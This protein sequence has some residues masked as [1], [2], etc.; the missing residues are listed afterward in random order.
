MDANGTFRISV[1][2]GDLTF[3][4][5]ALLLGH[6]H[7]TRLT[8]TEKIMD[9]L[10]GG[11][12]EQ[13]LDMGIYPVAI[14][15]HQI[16]INTHPNTERGIFVPHPKAVIIAG[17]GEEGKLRAADLVQSVRQAV[18]AWSQRLAEG[19]G[20]GSRAAPTTFELSSTLLG[21]GGTGVSPGEAAR[22]IAEGVYRANV[23]MAEEDEERGSSQT[24]SPRVAHLRF[25]ELYLD[26]AT[27]AWRSLRLQEAARPGRY[28][29]EEVVEEGTGALQRPLD[30]GYRGAEFDFISV[31]ATTDAGGLPVL[32]YTLDTRRA[33]SEVRAQRAQSLL[34]KELVA[35][36]SNDQNRDEQIGRTLFD[37]LIPIELEAYLAGSGEMQ[38]ELD[39]QTAAI[40]WELLDTTRA[41]DEDL[42]WALR[43]NLLRKLRISTFRERVVDAG[44]DA[45]ALVIGEPQAPAA[46]PR[47]YGARAE[48]EAVIARLAGTGGLSPDAVLGLI[49]EE[50]SEPGPGARDLVNALFDRPWRIV[51]IAGHGVPRVGGQ[52]GGVVLS[53]GAF[54][55]P[56]EIASM[57]TVPELVFLNCCHVGAAAAGELLNTYDRA[58]FASGVAG[59]LISIG[60]RCV[61]AAGWAV[62]D[63]GAKVFA[64]TFYASLVRGNRFIT[65]LGEARRAAY[66]HA[67]DQNTWAAYQC[68]GDPDWIFRQLPSDPNRVPTRVQ[69]DFSGVA[70]ATSL[71]L[72]L[73]R[74]FTEVRF[75]GADPALKLESLRQLETRYAKRWG[76]QG[77]VAEFFGDAFA[78]TG[79]IEAAFRWYEA[80]IAAPDASA[81]MRAAE[82]LSSLRIR[83][84]WTIVD[85]AARTRHGT[86]KGERSLEAAIARADVLLND[87]LTL[88]E[89]LVAV[90]RTVTRSALLGS[91]HK[92]RALVDDAAG[93]RAQGRRDLTQMKAR[94]SEALE[95]AAKSGV[96]PVSHLENLLLADVALNAG[97]NG[98]TLDAKSAAVVE[99]SRRK[100]DPSF[101]SVVG[102]T[103][104]AQYRALGRRRL[105]ANLHKLEKGY[106]DL[107][108]QVG[109]LRLWRP[110]YDRACLVLSNY[111]GRVADQEEKAAAQA[112]LA[113]LRDYA[114][115]PA[116]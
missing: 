42:P 31:A 114:H 96:D 23:R 2:N 4:R 20:K 60:V 116:K 46:F 27:E 95:L 47:L 50:A 79:D 48:A 105:A 61:I 112:L 14:G 83:H 57:R 82:R 40:P 76:M 109:S 19:G 81:S 55:G 115:P 29:V 102:A 1:I 21:S 38:I 89:K 67:P 18:I 107:H 63:D 9:R 88:L 59:E 5:D 32:S 52:A 92:H 97:T 77:D 41:A 10:L 6:Y 98:W 64:D 53:N 70:S 26:R 36:A 12:M 84:A 90:E 51:H 25:I 87:A 73:Q 16:F 72:A 11:A 22:L 99:R 111:G 66:R 100:S 15:S 110:V 44:A 33:R 93:R 113:L 104:L 69:D 8:G 71:T 37:L 35:T 75:Q 78:E 106:A 74:V 56:A 68:Y 49:S 85:A 80:S 3:E 34:I 43:V 17:L 108:R 91:A 45:S 94:Y 58:A 39:P 28:V 65:A 101:T 54:L 86:R 62:D 24:R 30:L 103:E 13:S 7:A